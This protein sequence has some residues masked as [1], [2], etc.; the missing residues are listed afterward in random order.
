M[1]HDPVLFYFDIVC[2]YAYLASTQLKRLENHYK[3][4]FQLQ[5]ILLGGILKALDTPT[6]MSTMPP[7]KL[8]HNFLDMH[9]WAEHWNVPFN[10]PTQHP[11]RTLLPQRCLHAFPEKTRELTTLFYRAYWVENLDVTDEQVMIDWLNKHSFA[12]EQL[13]RASKTEDV[14]HKLR[15]ATENALNKGVFG[16]PSFEIDGELFWG[17]DRLIF[18]EQRLEERRT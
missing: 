6:P 9:R 15:S 5:P 17:Q 2:P 13:I 18:V 3:I 14:K 12:G 10:F 11:Q 16:V 7:Q 4:E 8:R 1:S